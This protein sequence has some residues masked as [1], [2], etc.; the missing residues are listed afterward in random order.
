MILIILGIIALAILLSQ[1]I[2]LIAIK[3]IKKIKSSSKLMIVGDAIASAR[4]QVLFYNIHN[5][6]KFNEYWNS[7]LNAIRI[8][9]M[10]KEIPSV[11]LKTEGF[12]NGIKIMLAGLSDSTLDVVH[13]IKAIKHDF[14]EISFNEGVDRIKLE[15]I[16]SN[17]DVRYAKMRARKAGWSQNGKVKESISD[18]MKFSEKLSLTSGVSTSSSLVSHINEAKSTSTSMRYQILLPSNHP[19][20]SKLSDLGN[21][22]RFFH[23][24]NGKLYGLDSKFLGNKGNLFEF[25][26]VN[27]EPGKIYTGFSTSLDGGKHIVPSSAIYGITKFEDG[28]LPAIDDA[29]LAKPFNEEGGVDIYHKDLTETYLGPDTAQKFYDI[30]VK[31]H[32]EDENEDDYVSLGRAKEFYLDFPWI[33]GDI[34]TRDDSINSITKIVNSIKQANE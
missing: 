27:L 16:T 29:E 14:W 18:D 8:Y 9:A 25:D 20:A 17:L 33:E 2:L 31:K 1:I 10:G 34:S 4:E 32:Y 19:I 30:I 12:P 6:K 22:S 3:V 7:E 26:I 28:E 15:Q 21:L 5:V 24:W 11:A 13:V 23:V